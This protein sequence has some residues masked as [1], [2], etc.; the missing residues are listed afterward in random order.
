MTTAFDRFLAS[1]EAVASTD[2]IGMEFPSMDALK[3]YLHIH[4]KADPSNHSVEKKDDS[5][6]GG[7][8]IPPKLKE[9]QED[10]DAFMDTWEKAEDF[11]GHKLPKPEKLKG[12]GKKF[13]DESKSGKSRSDE[14]AAKDSKEMWD[15][16]DK[17]VSKAVDETGKE[18]NWP[19][20]AKKH[21]PKQQEFLGLT[22][23]KVSS[24][25]I[26]SRFLARALN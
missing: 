1:D 20:K 5:G 8:K 14:E 25:R 23:C 13:D 24:Q 17:A 2:Q 19:D 12:L 11:A 26:V 9:H 22:A 7:E 15:L 3:K 16:L 4:P 10:V 18:W 6:G 21:M